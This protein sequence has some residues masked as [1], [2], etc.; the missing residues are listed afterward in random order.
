MEQAERDILAELLGGLTRQRG[1]YLHLRSEAEGLRAE[2]GKAPEEADVGVILAATDE[3]QRC[4][5]ELQ[6]LEAAL[7]PLREAWGQ[8]RERYSSAQ[9]QPLAALVEELAALMQSLL[10]LEEENSR[11]VQRHAGALARELERA[12]RTRKAGDAYREQ[13]R[14]P[15]RPR[16]YDQKE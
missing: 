6:A 1:L 14:Q 15:G 8:V 9:R 12:R 7:A 2:A 3:K 4:L 10:A 13:E 11:L 16:F 5:S